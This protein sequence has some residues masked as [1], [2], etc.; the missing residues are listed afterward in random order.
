M[1]YYVLHY[2]CP[3]C[4]EAIQANLG[5]RGKVKSCTCGWITRVPIEQMPRWQSMIFGLRE[6]L[7]KLNPKEKHCPRIV[8]DVGERPR[9]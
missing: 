6:F 8:L 7:K 9:E 1:G 3:A 4:G 2:V 5:E